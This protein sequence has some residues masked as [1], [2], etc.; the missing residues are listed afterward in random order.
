MLNPSYF[1]IPH[2]YLRPTSQVLVLINGI[3]SEPD[4]NKADGFKVPP[5][6]NKIR[7]GQAL[8]T[9]C[10]KTVSVLMADPF[11]TKDGVTWILYCGH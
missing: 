7:E 10:S 8:K 4:E 9:S 5:L 3:Y 1:S 2:S 11:R 6:F